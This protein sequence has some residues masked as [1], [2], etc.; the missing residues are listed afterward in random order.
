MTTKK[1]KNKNKQ[2]KIQVKKHL[3]KVVLRA[4][5]ISLFL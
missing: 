3:N 2:K 4:Q 1:I 5:H